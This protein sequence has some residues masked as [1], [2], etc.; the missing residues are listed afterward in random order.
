MSPGS[1]T[2]RDRLHPA[3]DAART[4]SPTPTRTPIRAR[5]RT[6][7]SVVLVED[8]RCFT[9]S[10]AALRVA[11]PLER[12]YGLLAGLR[13]VPRPIRDAVYDLVARYRYRIFGK[14]DRCMT[15]AEDA[16]DRFLAYSDS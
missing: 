15:P 8:G 1:P 6:H 2:G 10:E 14:R 7:E 13:A 3:P 16:D 11:R 5:R 4:R 12:P 9:G